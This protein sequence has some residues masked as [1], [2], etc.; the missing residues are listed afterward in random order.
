MVNTGKEGLKALE[1]AKRLGSRFFF[2]WFLEIF[3]ERLIEQFKEYLAGYTPETIREMVLQKRYPYF[4][5][6]VFRSLRGFEE[7]LEKV[8]SKRI[9]EAIAEARPDLAEALYD[10]G[11]PKEPPEQKPGLLWIISFRKH[12]LQRCRGAG[13]GPEAVGDLL[14]KPR[15]EMVTA[16]CESCNRSWPVPKEEFDNITECPFC[17]ERTDQPPDTP[18][19][20]TEPPIA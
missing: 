16:T 9:F 7:Y 5:P 6:Q 18:P 14:E 1:K 10:M 3:H 20:P 13:E 19:T 8:K 11:D 17:H 4:E 2:E 12:F 15:P